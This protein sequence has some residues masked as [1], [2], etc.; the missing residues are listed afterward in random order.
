MSRAH[1]PSIIAVG[2]APSPSTAKD[3]KDHVETM[4][5][6]LNPNIFHFNYQK[7]LSRFC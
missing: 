4:S 5:V 2:A 6:V 7:T 3:L 1:L